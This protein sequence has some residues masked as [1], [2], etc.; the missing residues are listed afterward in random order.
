MQNMIR[1][2]FTLP[3][4]VYSDLRAE[5]SPRQRS[6]FVAEVVKKELKKKNKKL[7]YAEALRK[8]AGTIS[9]KDHPE[10]KDLDSIV[11]WVNAGRAA[12]NR[13]Y[14]YIPYGGKKKR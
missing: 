1:V 5:I 4:D 7:S 13:D 11:A 10:W 14:S 6:R 12:A 2:N 8:V 9:A 3:W